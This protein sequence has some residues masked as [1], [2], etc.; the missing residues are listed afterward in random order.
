M[1]G[2]VRAVIVIVEE[3]VREESRTM[4]AGAIGASISPLASDG[5]NETFGL[6]VGLW[7][8]GFGEEMFEAQLVAGSGKEFGT[9]GRT[10]IGEDVLDEDAVISVKGDGLVEGGQDTGSFFIGQE[11]G[12]SDPRMVINGDMQAFHAGARIA[13][14]PVAGGAD[15]WLVKTSKFFNIKMK[16]FAGGGAF[17][18]DNW[19]LGRIEER[20]SAHLKHSGAVETRVVPVDP[21]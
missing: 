18:A 17:V 14:R 9:I 7:A 11:A 15:A 20:R 16:E 2:G 19:R 3:E 1:Q 12:K 5:L 8:I 10:A 6:A 13:M 21:A 4:G